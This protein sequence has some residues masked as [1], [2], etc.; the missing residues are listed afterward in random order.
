MAEPR[1]F[2]GLMSGTSVDA[3]DAVIVQCEPFQILHAITQPFPAAW[4]DFALALG[5]GQA[6]VD[7]DQLGQFDIAMGEALA[8]SALALLAHAQLERQDIIAIGS[9]GQTVRHRPQGTYPFTLQLGCPH[10]I[11]ERTGI[12][13][14]A[15]FRRR[16]VAAG[17][18]GAPLVPAFHHA[19]FGARA[20]RVAVL[21]L[22][23]IANV[24]LMDADSVRGFDTGPANA[25]LDAHFQSLKAELGFDRNGA[26]AASGTA[27]MQSVQALLADPFFAKTGPKST[28]RET[29]QLAW[30]FARAPELAALSNADRQA[31]FAELSAQSAARAL[32]DFGAEHNLVCGGGVHNADL[33]RRI[34]RELGPAQT[35]YSTADCGVD[36]D[37]VEAAAFAWLA[38]RTMAGHTGN[39]AAVTGARGAR[40]L[41]AVV[42]A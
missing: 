39:L 40:V 26:F 3:I 17:G 28:G 27:H 1:R 15:E 7:L 24:T 30:A 22:G 42:H 11:A 36:P 20:K 6:M 19:I 5:Q 10:V 32:L 16:D 12:C 13:T 37:Y 2:I 21:N 14:V 29:F 34:Q 35:L 25:L 23:G 4:R 31:S 9:H 38:E 41:G 33:L 18:Q 8:A